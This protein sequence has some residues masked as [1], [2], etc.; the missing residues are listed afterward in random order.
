MFFKD[1]GNKGKCMTELSS[2]G[3]ICQ[4]WLTN[5]SI[6]SI[7][8]RTRSSTSSILLWVQQCQSQNK[9]SKTFGKLNRIHLQ[10][11]ST[12]P[13]YVSGAQG[14]CLGG[15]RCAWRRRRRRGHWLHR[16]LHRT[17]SRGWHSGSSA[18]WNP[19]LREKLPEVSH[20]ESLN[21]GYSQRFWIQ[22]NRP[23]FK[24]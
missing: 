23:L 12:D 22:E 7:R 5:S 6:N 15:R 11:E 4:L 1:V 3:F 16:N 18:L 8:I 20:D 17:F 24:L 13:T 21:L 2:N 19:D 10:P 9:C 14:S